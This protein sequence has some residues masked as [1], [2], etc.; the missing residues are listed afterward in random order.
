MSH[1]IP[2]PLRRLVAQR[3]LFRCEY[4]R[5]HEE[6]SFLPFEI[7]HIISL[8]HGGGNEYENLAYACPHCNQHKG[9][10][11][12]TFL[13]SYKDIVAIFNPREHEWQAHFDV[14]EGEILGKTRTAEATIKLLKLNEP[15]RIILRR[16]L[17]ETNRYP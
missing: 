13:K 2:I 15:E 14:E 12:T 8:K 1:Y 3:A 4:C 16:L 10:D 17:I 7:D 5:T 6:D 11:L 9:T